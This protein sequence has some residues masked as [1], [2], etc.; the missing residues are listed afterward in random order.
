MNPTPRWPHLPLR[1]WLLISH[2]LAMLVPLAAVFATGALSQDL[3]NQTREDIDHQ[4]TLMAMWVAAEIRHARVLDHQATVGDIA[5]DL[6]EGLAEARAQTLA[7]FRVLDAEGYVVASS[8]G[9]GVGSH[10]AARPEVREALVG[11]TETVVKPRDRPDNAPLSSASRRAR[12]RVFLARPVFVD[13]AVEGVVYISRTPREQVQAIYQMAPRLSLGLVISL[14]LTSAL[15]VG[16][17]TFFSRSLMRLAAVARRFAAGEDLQLASELS[18]PSASRV[19]EVRT[20]T[21]SV[22]TMAARL[23]ARVGY[24]SEF[25][26]HV[27][28]EFRTPITT[29]RGTVELLRDDDDMPAEQRARFLENAL[30]DLDR[31]Q[32]LVTGL[33]ALARAEEGVPHQPL[34]LHELLLEA[35]DD[36][37]VTGRAGVVLGDAEQLRA[38]V[39]NLVENAISYGKPPF[40]LQARSDK[41]TTGFEVVDHGPGISA[42]NQKKV[43]ERFFTTGRVGGG[44]G[45]GLA[46]VQTIVARHGGVVD[47]VSVPGLTQFRV[48]LP[49]FDRSMT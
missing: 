18:Y 27:A 17:A 10:L 26:G 23:A 11:G 3:L 25:A 49:R 24:I 45:I 2:L 8:S 16:S 20:V 43:F 42:A 12:V 38:V 14:F 46:L 35:S 28:H 6:G 9:N 21:A 1:E 29:L 44:T 41:A 19:G 34:E 48:S 30:Q 13:G 7:G 40:L 47:V 5:G 4:S 36:V 37:V 22:L 33:L 39:R 31:L 32:R 15:G